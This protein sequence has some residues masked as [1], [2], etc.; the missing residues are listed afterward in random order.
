[1]QLADAFEDPGPSAPVK[2]WVVLALAKRRV[3]GTCG[4]AM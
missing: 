4:L 3:V 1:M 2:R